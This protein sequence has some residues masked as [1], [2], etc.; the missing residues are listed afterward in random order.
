MKRR[1]FM[2]KSGAAGAG[3]VMTNLIQNKTFAKNDEVTL[4]IIGNM[5]RTK[6]RTSSAKIQPDRRGRHTTAQL[7][8]CAKSYATLAGRD[9][10][11]CLYGQRTLL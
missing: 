9:H 6:I 4:A 8:A 2:I 11:G 1:D 7:S 5:G 3:L 10:W